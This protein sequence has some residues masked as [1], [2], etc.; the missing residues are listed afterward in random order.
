MKEHIGIFGNRGA[1]TAGLIQ[2]LI[3]DQQSSGTEIVL[4]SQNTER[5]PFPEF[6]GFVRGE[7]TSSDVLE[8]AGVTDAA[9]IIIHSSTDYESICI[10]LTVKEINHTTL[11]VVRPTDPRNVS[12]MRLPCY[13]RSVSRHAVE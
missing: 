12:I 9:K 13:S 3:A 11:L 2:E 8:R 7:P 6:I 5:K 10:A 1:E 4:C